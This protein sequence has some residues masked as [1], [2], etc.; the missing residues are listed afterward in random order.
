MR[1]TSTAGS[2]SRME[3][4]CFRREITACTSCWVNRET[5]EMLYNTRRY[6]ITPGMNEYD[7][8]VAYIYQD[9]LGIGVLAAHS[10]HRRFWS[11]VRSGADLQE[12][13]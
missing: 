1:T 4:T 12:V 11:R 7:T 6:Y 3:M 8:Y 13:V 5:E 9:G 2:I 10:G